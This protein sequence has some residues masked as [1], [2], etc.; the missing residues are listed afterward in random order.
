[1][2][3]IFQTNQAKR[4]LWD[5]RKRPSPFLLHDI[6]FFF[7]LSSL[8]LVNSGGG[9]GAAVGALS[10]TS[11]LSRG[12]R[13]RIH[14]HSWSTNITSYH[15]RRAPLVLVSP[16]SLSHREQA[17]ANRG[18]VATILATAGSISAFSHASAAF[19]YFT[20]AASN[21]AWPSLCAPPWWIFVPAV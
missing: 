21:P 11:P 17:K 4:A 6:K 18:D 3:D 5:K 20:L 7:H 19:S 13:A 2:L 15:A 14:L 10:S 16:L 12:P 1:M 9:G 8:S